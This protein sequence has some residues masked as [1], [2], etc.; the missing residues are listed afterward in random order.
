MIRVNV[1]NN[2]ILPKVTTSQHSAQNVGCS[3]LSFTVSFPFGF[4]E[5]Y[6]F[7]FLQELLLPVSFAGFFSSLQPLNVGGCQIEILVFC[8]STFILSLSNLSLFCG[9]KYPFPLH[10]YLS[11]RRKLGRIK[12]IWPMKVL[13]SINGIANTKIEESCALFHFKG[14]PSSTQAKHETIPF[15]I[16]I[17]S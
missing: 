15:Q 3:T 6:I 13:K 4:S 1:S 7:S 2:S 8:L 10:S 11:F 14:T 17:S 16:R 9:L 12:G 5:H